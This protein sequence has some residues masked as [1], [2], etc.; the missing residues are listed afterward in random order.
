MKSL[1][2]SSM[3]Q[4]QSMFCYQAYEYQLIKVILDF[5]C[6]GPAFRSP[7]CFGKNL[8]NSLMSL[9]RTQFNSATAKPQPSG[10]QSKVFLRYDN[11][12][13]LLQLYKLS[14]CAL[15]HNVKQ[16]LLHWLLKASAEDLHVFRIDS[17]LKDT[18]SEWFVAN[19]FESFSLLPVSQN[20]CRLVS[21]C[22]SVHT[23]FFLYLL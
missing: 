11:L 2:R 10:L 15:L 18:L 4:N 21:S 13:I 6:A 17:Y 1:S 7:S 3:K 19:W 5:Y 23:W 14:I 9:S 12:A 20:M 8:R 16:A 22:V